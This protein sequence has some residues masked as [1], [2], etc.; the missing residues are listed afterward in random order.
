MPELI[1]PKER[2]SVEYVIWGS[3]IK[4]EDLKAHYCAGMNAYSVYC[5][6]THPYGKTIEKVLSSIPLN[7]RKQ[8]A[9]AYDTFGD[10]TSTLTSLNDK[11]LAI[12]GF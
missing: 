12:L 1:P 4:T 11:H 7:S 3:D 5:A 9:C 8:L 10:N 2:L 6:D